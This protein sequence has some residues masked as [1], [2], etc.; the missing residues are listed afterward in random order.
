MILKQRLLFDKFNSKDILIGSFQSNNLDYY[1]HVKIK[2][3][4]NTIHKWR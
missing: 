3:L 4:F 2:T 1:L